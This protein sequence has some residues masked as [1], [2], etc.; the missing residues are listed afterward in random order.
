M[1]FA[2]QFFI[3]L[4]VSFI[5]DVLRSFLPIPVPGS[6]YGFIILLAV[7]K[8]KIILLSHVKET[9]MFL[10]EIMP[11]MFIPPA[12]GLLESW[13]SLKDIYLPVLFI[14]LVST[15]IV[16]GVTGRLTQYVLRQ[17]RRKIID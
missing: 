1:R 7:L 3:I 14:T 15:I 6:I 2:K 10:I 4:S 17:E 9:G 16:M 11:L 5:G 12:V 13:I 8:L